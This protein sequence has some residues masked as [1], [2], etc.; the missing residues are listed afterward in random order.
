MKKGSDFLVPSVSALLARLAE[1]TSYEQVFVCGGAQVYEA[2][3]PYCRKIV[4]T[5]MDT[6]Y[7]CDTYWFIPEQFRLTESS[8]VEERFEV[9]ERM[10]RAD[11][12]YADLLRQVVFA[13]HLLG[14]PRRTAY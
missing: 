10:P 4:R 6:L 14:A 13:T 8:E 11:E 7:A 12:V 1:H 2:L 3:L 5:R 9:Y